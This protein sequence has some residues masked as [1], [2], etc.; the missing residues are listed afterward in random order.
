VNA[1]SEILATT[2]LLR[3]FDPSADSMKTQKLLYFI[4]GSYLA[5]TGKPLFPESPQ[6]W[7]YG[8]VYPRVYFD[9]RNN[10]GAIQHANTSILTNAQRELIAAV[11]EKFKG[12]SATSLMKKTHEPGPWTEARTGLPDGAS[13]Q[14]SI[15]HQSMMRYFSR[16]G[17]AIVSPHTCSESRWDEL[18]EGLMESEEKRWAGLLARL[19]S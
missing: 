1:S 8:P 12:I 16:P 17:M 13:S 14:K 3:E 9:I 18:P 7:T 15:T 4:Q 6:A 19:A 2:R 11:V 5:Q 10:R